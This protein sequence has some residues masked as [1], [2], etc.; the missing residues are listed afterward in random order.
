MVIDAR[1][2]FAQRVYETYTLALDNDTR[3]TELII[4]YKER[5]SAFLYAKIA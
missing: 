4:W 3:M 5:R 1:K 2:L